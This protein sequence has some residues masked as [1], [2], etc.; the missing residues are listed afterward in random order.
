MPLASLWIQ[1]L[2]TILGLYISFILL[3]VFVLLFGPSPT[4]RYGIV[5]KLHV[6]ITDSL[7]T[8]LG[9]GL[10]KVC[11]EGSS[12]K[13][14]GCWAYLSNQ[15][16]PFLQILYLFF[17][18]GSIG[19][20][21]YSGY[22]LL[23]ATSLPSF[24]KKIVIP[25]VIVFTY[26]CFFLASAIGPGEINAQNVKRA[27]ETYPYDYLLYD[28]KICKT[29]KFR[30]A[31][32]VCWYGTFLVSH[33]FVSRMYDSPM[34]KFLVVTNRWDQ[35]GILRNYHLFIYQMQLDRSLGALGV[36]ASLAGL[37]VFLFFLYNL[38]LVATNVTTNESFKWEDVGELLYRGEFV[39]VTEYD[40][41]GTQVGP[42]RYEVRDRRHP[43]HPQYTGLPAPQ[44][45]Q[46]QARTGQ[47]GANNGF[48][49]VENV[50]RSK[51]E[52]VNIYD[53][54]VRENIRSVLWPPSLEAAGSQGG[55]RGQR[56]IQ[57]RVK[58]SMKGA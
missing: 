18:T 8:Y 5:G 45:A 56:T 4:F 32:Q 7:W 41:T 22:D 21:L 30:N 58:K 17:I 9:K 42:R 38:Y 49:V 16:N 13:C 15:R 12:T 39:E 1:E 53:Q 23:D 26:A 36:F 46:N 37:V 51:R 14:S 33:I 44:Q 52:I 27:L 25:T 34:Y 2:L 20:F 35:L 57:E 31:V 19:T 50:I 40:P 47:A 28:P 43:S 54:G 11:G 24:H 10:R 6:F 29:C 3:L 48:T 55:S